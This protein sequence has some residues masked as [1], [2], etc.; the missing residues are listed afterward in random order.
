[1][2]LVVAV[3]SGTNACS[4]L[5]SPSKADA[6]ASPVVPLCCG[7]DVCAG[8]KL[9]CPNWFFCRRESWIICTPTLKL[10]L[11]FSQVRSVPTLH[12]GLFLS[13][14]PCWPR[15]GMFQELLVPVKPVAN[16]PP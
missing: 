8:E 6:S 1:M 9:S 13:R 16:H 5:G 4:P 11:P 2:V 3:A 14:G 7:S 12:V 10:C 15:S